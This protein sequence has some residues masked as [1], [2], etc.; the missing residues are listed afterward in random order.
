[1]LW[2]HFSSA[3][4]GCARPSRW[5]LWR[6]GTSSRSTHRRSGGRQSAAVTGCSGRGSRGIGA[7]GGRPLVFVQPTTVRA[8]QRRRCREHWARLN[9]REPGQPTV[10]KEIRA[11]IREISAANPGWGPPWILGELRKLGIP[12][13]N[14][15]VEKHPVRLRRAPSPAWRALLKKHV[16][17][18][19]ALRFSSPC[20]R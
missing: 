16:T 8:W 11:L 17:E 19:V 7:T 5:R 1:M 10:S 20:P 6:S 4:S 14:S 9:R 18:L 15:T 3:R 12:V 2:S 13:A